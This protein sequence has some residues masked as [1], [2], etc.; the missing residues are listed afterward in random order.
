MKTPITVVI[1]ALFLIPAVDA[2]DRPGATQREPFDAHLTIEDK[3]VNTR[4]K[5]ARGLEL[6]E[7]IVSSRRA[8]GINTSR[9]NAKNSGSAAEGCPQPSS[10]AFDTHLSI[11]DKRDPKGGLRGQAPNRGYVVGSQGVNRMTG[12]T[13]NEEGIESPCHIDKGTGRPTGKRVHVAQGEVNGDGVAEGVRF[14]GRPTC[15]DGVCRTKH[16]TAKNTINNVR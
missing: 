2:Q 11:D 4:K 5:G 7:V 16:D 3:D 13:V 6:E 1:A 9:S 14:Q 8:A 15:P 10:R 12:I